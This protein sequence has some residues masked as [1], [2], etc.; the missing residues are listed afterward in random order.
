M[1]HKMLAVS[2]GQ[3]TSKPLHPIDHDNHGDTRDRFGLPK[4]CQRFLSI[5]FADRPSLHSMLP[6]R[7]WPF[8]YRKTTEHDHMA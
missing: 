1:A 7:E 2:G 3:W 4:L 5:R 6:V 8:T